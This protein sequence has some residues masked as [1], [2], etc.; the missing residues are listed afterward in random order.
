MWSRSASTGSFIDRRKYALDVV[1]SQLRTARSSLNF[2]RKIRKLLPVK[3]GIHTWWFSKSPPA[4]ANTSG[5]WLS[6][7]HSRRGESSTRSVSLSL[8]GGGVTR[9]LLN[10]LLRVGKMEVVSESSAMVVVTVSCSGDGWQF[11][12]EC[13]GQYSPIWVVDHIDFVVVFCFGYLWLNRYF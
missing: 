1:S 3:M 8:P 9:S 5:K 6:A 11:G 7:L 12:D 13:G 2:S 4:R 10:G